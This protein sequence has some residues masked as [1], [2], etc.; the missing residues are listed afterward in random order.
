MNS[1]KT[2]TRNVNLGLIGMIIL[3]SLFVYVAMELTQRSD[4]GAEQARAERTLSR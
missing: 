2:D 3:M 4:M 1:K